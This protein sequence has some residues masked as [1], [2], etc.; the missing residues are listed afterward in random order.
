VGSQ[1]PSIWH[2]LLPQ[3]LVLRRA[4]GTDSVGCR[5]GCNIRA[6]YH[7]LQAHGVST[8][9]SVHMKSSLSAKWG[10]VGC[11]SLSSRM[12][13][14]YLGNILQ[15]VGTMTYIIVASVLLYLVSVIF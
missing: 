1:A 2:L 12:L 6:V 11:L 14:V 13:S 3:A 15:G 7:L 4:D 5:T 10:S 9:E 8:A